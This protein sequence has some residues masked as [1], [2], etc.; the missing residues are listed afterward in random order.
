MA[1][2]PLVHVIDDDEAV[3]DSLAVLFTAADIGVKTYA[4][5]QAFLDDLPN[6]RSGVVLT[7]VQMPHMNGFDLLARLAVLRSELPV[8]VMTGRGNLGTAVD[9][10]ARGAAAFI[11]KPFDAD[12]LLLAVRS[13]MPPA[14]A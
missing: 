11:R 13:A 8:I 5:A 3:R 4:S 10:L 12:A 6:V 2:E 1:A 14:G 7:D 9:A